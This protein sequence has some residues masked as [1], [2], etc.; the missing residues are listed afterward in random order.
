MRKKLLIQIPVLL[1]GGATVNIVHPMNGLAMSMLGKATFGE[2][3]T[4]VTRSLLGQILGP[5]MLL[6]LGLRVCL[7]SKLVLSQHETS[8]VQWRL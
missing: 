5:C 8:S 1:A 4:L 6:P 3:L 7:P 2:L